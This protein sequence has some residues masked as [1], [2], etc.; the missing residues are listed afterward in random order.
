MWRCLKILKLELPYD[1]TIPLMGICPREMKSIGRRDICTPMVIAGLFTIART[2]SQPK[3]PAT[4]E[5]MKKT[6]YIHKRL[7]LFSHK[8]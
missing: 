7:V 3:C 5:R 8:E 6:V 4:D 2:L 1:L